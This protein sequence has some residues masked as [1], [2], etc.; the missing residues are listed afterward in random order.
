MSCILFCI[1]RRGPLHRHQ[2]PFVSLSLFWFPSWTRLFQLLKWLKIRLLGF[3][4]RMLWRLGLLLFLLH[5]GRP[6]LN[7]LQVHSAIAHSEIS[8]YELLHLFLVGS[9]L[10]TSW[11][12]LYWLLGSRERCYIWEL[13]L[14]RRGCSLSSLYSRY[15]SL[16]VGRLCWASLRFRACYLWNWLN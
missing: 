4:I 16:W 8:L 6:C 3:C 1:C 9:I 10:N 12:L 13:G 15:V 2:N 7:R 14:V 5:D 11:S